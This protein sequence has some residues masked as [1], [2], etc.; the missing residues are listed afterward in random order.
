M[1]V[2]SS[3]RLALAYSPLMSKMIWPTGYVGMPAGV[4]GSS[5]ASS[6]SFGG[7]SSVYGDSS[8][9]RT[10]AWMISPIPAGVG[11]VEGAMALAFASLGVPTARAAVLAVTYRGLSFWLPFLVGLFT[12]HQQNALVLKEPKP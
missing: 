8:L 6:L 12:L 5:L 7:F 2:P 10:L 1:A 9:M 3:W 11:M 4:N